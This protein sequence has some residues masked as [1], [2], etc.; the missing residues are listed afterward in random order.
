VDHPHIGDVPLER[1]NAA[2]IT[3]LFDTIGRFNAELERQRTE[4][5]ALIEIEGNVRTQPRTVGASTQHRIMATLRAALNAA[6]KQRQLTWNP[7]A[8]VELPPAKPAARQ[9]WTHEQVARFLAVTAD[10]ELAV[11]YRIVVLR[12]LR[13]GEL[14]GLRWSGA[15]LENGV[16]AVD[17]SILEL[18]G[19]LQPGVPKTAAGVRRVFLD[20]ETAALLRE[21]RKAQLAARLRAGADWEDHDLIFCRDD[22]RPLRPSVEYRRIRRLAADAGCR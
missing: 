6:V 12:G 4:D 21:H 13:R 22:G 18:D 10:D 1:L 17:H 11:L 15:D 19:H 14:F 3:S 16:L 5:R 8:G 9:R 7:C 20:A 2:H